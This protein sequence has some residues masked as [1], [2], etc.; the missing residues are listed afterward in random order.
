MWFSPTLLGSFFSIY[1]CSVITMFQGEGHTQHRADREFV[2]TESRRFAQS[3]A[4]PIVLGVS[5]DQTV[6]KEFRGIL[7]NS[8]RGGVGGWGKGSRK[9]ENDKILEAPTEVSVTW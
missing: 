8:L 4:D 9:T 3:T 2:S 5:E 6:F 1:T 7:G